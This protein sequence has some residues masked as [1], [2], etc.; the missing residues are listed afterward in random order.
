MKWA[1]YRA[2]P[3][4]RGGEVAHPVGTA[5]PQFHP[6]CLVEKRARGW[7]SFVVFKRCQKYGYFLCHFSVYKRQKN[8]V[9]AHVWVSCGLQAAGHSLCL[10]LLSAAAGRPHLPYCRGL[11]VP[12]PPLTCV[13]SLLVPIL[14]IYCPIVLIHTCE[15]VKVITVA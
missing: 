3:E 15:E 5:A 1:R 10:G 8:L 12:W 13:R 6:G 2:G 11:P 14:P 9:T 7:Q 4:D